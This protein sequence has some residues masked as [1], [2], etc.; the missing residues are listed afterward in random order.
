MNNLN[1]VVTMSS[2]GNGPCRGS[3]CPTIFADECGNYYFQGKIVP[4]ID[5]KKLNIPYD[6]DIVLVP[7]ELVN[8]L[9]KKKGIEMG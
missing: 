2:E 9:I 4:S 5:K 8:N 6:E 7:E 3:A 1:V